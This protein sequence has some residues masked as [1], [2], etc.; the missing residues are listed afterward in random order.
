MFLVSFWSGFS[1]YHRGF[2]KS[3]IMSVSNR[4]TKSCEEGFTEKKNIYIGRYR[5]KGKHIWQM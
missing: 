5:L 2:T 3:K 4:E 1:A